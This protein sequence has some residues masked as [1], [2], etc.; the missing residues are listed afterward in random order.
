VSELRR[1]LRAITADGAASSV[2]VGVGETYLPAFV[3]VLSASQLASG[4]VASVPLVAGA[5][6]QLVSP[7]MVRRF[8]S[9]RLW[10]TL[11]AAI[12]AVVF[13]P[14]ILPAVLGSIPVSLVFVIAS[15]YWA[16]G[17]AGAPAWNAWVETLVPEKIRSG[18]FAR[19]T[20]VSQLGLMVGFVV[21]GLT[22]QAAGGRDPLAGFAVLFLLAAT[23]RLVSVRCLAMQ[24]EPSPPAEG[25]PLPGFK[26]LL[27][28]LRT[29]T[30]GRVLLFMLTM[31]LAVWIASP[32][33]TAYMFV[34]LGLSYAGFVVLVCTA[35]AAKI[36][37]LPVLGRAI[38]RWGPRR[39]LWTT[40][41][42]IAPL[43]ALWSVSDNF[44]YLM[45]LQLMAGAAWGGYELATLLSFFDSIPRN[46]RVGILT[47][48]NVANAGA[49]VVGSLLGGTLLG[50]LGAGRGAYAMLFAASAV[51]RFGALALLVRVPQVNVR[52]LWSALRSMALRPAVA[53]LDR[54]I[55]RSL[56]G[57]KDMALRPATCAAAA[58]I[59]PARQPLD[60]EP[61]PA[62]PIAMA[63]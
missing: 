62:T 51:A 38:E 56:P 14:L 6:L 45:G 33:F 39:V 40:G 12:Q 49:I 2:M 61:A 34:H 63:D 24:R 59:A 42:A 9:Y 41:L 53:A 7:Y 18:Y 4:L 1:D 43:P 21:G 57:N 26:T 31:Q 5:L 30:D 23:A 36:A 52:A 10:V 32:Y 29:D 55:L 50:A 20:R 22:L 15:I 3:L 58:A 27:A 48:F 19:R 17:M 25:I 28:S 37:A 44:A 54:P 47:I 11:C 46:K 13:L 60:W 8:G 35:Y 16:T